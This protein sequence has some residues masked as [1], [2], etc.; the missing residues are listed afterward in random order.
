MKRK[1]KMSKGKSFLDDAKESIKDTINEVLHEEI[2]SGKEVDHLKKVKTIINIL[3]WESANIIGRIEKIEKTD[4]FEEEN[5][6]IHLPIFNKN[7]LSNIEKEEIKEVKEGMGISILTIDF[8]K[9]E[10]D[11]LIGALSFIPIPF[12][13]NVKDVSQ[14][15]VIEPIE[16]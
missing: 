11:K 7:R 13:G 6:S 15:R 1:D 3:T 16:K 5:D 12:E 2:I 8:V 9:Q 10:I 14:P 4:N